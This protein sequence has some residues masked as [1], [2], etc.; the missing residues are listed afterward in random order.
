ML[1][2]TSNAHLIQT[3]C[4]TPPREIQYQRVAR[5]PIYLSNHHRSSNFILYNLSW[6]DL[7]YGHEDRTSPE[8]RARPG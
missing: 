5:P 8:P 6:N 7:R 3:V 1:A 2:L 4:F